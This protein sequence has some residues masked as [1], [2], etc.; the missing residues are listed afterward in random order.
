MYQSNV[1]TIP[2]ANRSLNAVA[3]QK[4]VLCADCDV[5]SDSPHD[6]CMVC[7]SRSLVNIS[8]MLGGSLPKN[9]ATLLRQE[10]V[11]ITRELVVNFPTPHRVR[12]KIAV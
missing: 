1:C 9:R 8:R 6:V 7:G 2:P 4:A 11:E 5:V 10:P 12:R 3:L